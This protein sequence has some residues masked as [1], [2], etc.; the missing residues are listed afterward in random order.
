MS[1]SVLRAEATWPTSGQAPPETLG[2][3]RARL[4]GPERRRCRLSRC[5][6][7]RSSHRRRNATVPW[8][9][10]G[11]VF[12]PPCR[13]A[14]PVLRR[15]G[16]GPPRGTEARWKFWTAGRGVACCSRG[17]RAAPAGTSTAGG[18]DLARRIASIR[19]REATCCA[20]SAG[21]RRRF[22]PTWPRGPE[23]ADTG[24]SRLTGFS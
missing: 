11:K 8:D 14:R 2:V 5:S 22:S 12:A 10:S 24:N 19:R 13:C 23:V 6:G 9:R 3:R 17:A 18:P 15:P 7:S 20:L 1:A 4:R 16:V 21:P